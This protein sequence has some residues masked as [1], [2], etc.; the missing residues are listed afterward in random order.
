MANLSFTRQSKS[1]EGFTKKESIK[2][3]DYS[4]IEDDKKLIKLILTCAIVP[5]VIEII[6]FIIT[7]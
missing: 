2:I 4:I 6:V 7:I 1:D 3:L 5:M